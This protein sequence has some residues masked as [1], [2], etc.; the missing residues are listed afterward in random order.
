MVRSSPWS[1]RLWT[2]T[3]VVYQSSKT[4]CI[5]KVFPTRSLTSAAQGVYL[6]H[7]E[8]QEDDWRW[9]MYDTVKGSVG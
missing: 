4:A 7:S 3:A 1:W 5:S 8:T 2:E 9:H 6:Q